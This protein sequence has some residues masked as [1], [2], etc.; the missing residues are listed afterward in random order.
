MKL[1]NELLNTQYKLDKADDEIRKF[2]Q[3]V[4]DKQLQADSRLLSNTNKDLMEKT[5]ILVEIKQ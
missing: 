4:N 5:K 2:S 3:L 1:E